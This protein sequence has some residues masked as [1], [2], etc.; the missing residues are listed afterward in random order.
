MAATAANL[1]K[2]ELHGWTNDF[3]VPKIEFEMH[4]PCGSNYVANVSPRR[5]TPKWQRG[6]QSV[7]LPRNQGKPLRS[8]FIIKENNFFNSE[9][10]A[11]LSRYA[12]N[13]YLFQLTAVKITDKNIMK[14]RKKLVIKKEEE[15]KALNHVKSS[16][17]TQ[18]SAEENVYG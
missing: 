13:F 4:S 1:F 12:G 6:V 18:T 16:K 15:R 7:N 17:S 11:R 2:C 8:I 9:F 14:T 5:S 3:F 10:I